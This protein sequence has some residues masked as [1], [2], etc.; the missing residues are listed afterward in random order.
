MSIDTWM[1]ERNNGEKFEDLIIWQDSDKLMAALWK[2]KSK[3]PYAFYKF[4]TE[5]QLNQYIANQ[6]KAATARML[7]QREEEK[8]NSA[9][10]AEY[11]CNV[12]IGDI[13]VAS[14]G[15]EQTNVNFYQII[16][17]KNKTVQL[18]EIGYIHDELSWCGAMSEYVIADAQHK[19]GEPF[20]R[21]LLLRA[22]KGTVHAHI[23]INDCYS[24]YPWSGRPEYHSWY[25]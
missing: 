24:A 18:Q 8:I 7:A 16:S 13:W 5:K 19:I 15:Y 17:I 10:I 3:K 14:W 11:Q 6:K 22:Y 21:R 4:R 23:K 25:Y 12:K 9:A 1:N 20:T 2:G